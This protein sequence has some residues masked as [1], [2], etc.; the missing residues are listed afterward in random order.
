MDN[1][2][3]YYDVNLKFGRLKDSGFE[4]DKVEWGK[5]T[6]SNKYEHYTFIR[7][8]LEDADGI[9]NLFRKTGLII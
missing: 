2:N 9:T 1:I 3:N 7:L 6:K 8:N 5:P 4:K